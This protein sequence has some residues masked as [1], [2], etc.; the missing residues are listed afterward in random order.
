MHLLD[1]RST[2]AQPMYLRGSSASSAHRY[3]ESIGT[4]SS[5]LIIM[6]MLMQLYASSVWSV[7]GDT[8]GMGCVPVYGRRVS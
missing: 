5:D 7:S 8:I 6:L 2:R 4:V 1:F 3:R